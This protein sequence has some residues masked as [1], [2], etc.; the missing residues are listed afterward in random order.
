MSARTT[1]APEVAR[2]YAECEA[3]A[4]AHDENFPTASRLL[5]RELSRHLGAFYASKK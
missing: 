2:A 4:R 1:L 5:P 3:I